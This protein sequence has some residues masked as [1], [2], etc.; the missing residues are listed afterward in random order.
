MI[1]NFHKFFS[2]HTS[3]KSGGY[4]YESEYDDIDDEAEDYFVEDSYMD[5]SDADDEFFD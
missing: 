4:A 2:R 3:N 5:S 1:G